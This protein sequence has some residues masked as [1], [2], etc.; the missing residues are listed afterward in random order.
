MKHWIKFIVTAA[1]LLIVM[2]IAVAAAEGG[3]GILTAENGGVSL[4][5]NLPEG[6]TETI[7]SLRVKLLVSVE[8]GAISEPGFQFESS[9][10]SAIRDAAVSRGADGNYQVDIVLSGKKDQGIFH[11][12]AYAKI[13]TL[14]VQPA[15]KDYK[16][17]VEIAGEGGEPSVTYMDAGGTGEMTAM[18]ASAEAAVLESTGVSE[19]DSAFYKKPTLKATVKKGTNSVIFEWKRITGAD[20]YMIYQYQSKTK[21]YKSV[22]TVKN[23]AVTAYSAK[24][25]YAATHSFKMRAYRLAADGGKEYGPY[26][27]VIKA[28]LPPAKV[29]SLSVKSK[30]GQKATLS[31][32]KVSGAKGYQIYRSKKKKGKYKLLKTIKKGTTKKYSVKKPTGN[33][34]Y[35]Y[36][37]RAYVTGPKGKRAYGQFS[38]VRSLKANR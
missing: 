1:F 38:A 18:L 34:T 22:K 10:E 2:P 4:A 29:K 15:S 8:N 14:K 30:D 27:S 6:Q 20:G 33:V 9:V 31:W 35:Y 7:T 28:T 37:V 32:K 23:P 21:K 36:K 19:A 24:F 26:S 25:S 17:K 3:S 5:L 12:S 11:E 13:G 16:V